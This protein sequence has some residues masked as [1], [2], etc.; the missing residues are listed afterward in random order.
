[1]K[2]YSKQKGFSTI[3][4]SVALLIITVGLTAAT[5]VIFG[6]RSFSSDSGLDNEALYKAQRQIEDAR[7]SARASFGSVIS[8]SSND[9]IYFKEVVVS[10]GSQPYSKNVISRISWTAPGPRSEKIELSTTL[11]DWKNALVKNQPCLTPLSGDWQHPQMA[12]Y[13]FGKDLLGDSS[14]GYPL[15]G[16]TVLNSKLYVTVN[17]TNGNNFPSLFI[18]DVSKPGVKPALLTSADNDPG[19]KSGL[20]AITV[21]GNYAYV[22]NANNPN[23]STCATCGQLQIFDI[24]KTPPQVIDTFKVPGV[25][26]KNGQSIGTSIFYKGGIVYLG[27]AKTPD[28]ATGDTEFNLIDVG[29]G[30]HGGSP[31][32]PV[33]LGGYQVGNGVNAIYA[34]GKYAYIATPNS[35]NMTILDVSDPT[36]PTRAGGYSPG[37]GSNGESLFVT[38]STVYLGRTFGTNEFY[39][40]NVQNPASITVLGSKD[41]GSGSSTS[42]NGVVLRSNL[43]FLITNT[44]FQIWNVANPASIT[45]WATPL[46]LPAGSGTTI[47][48]STDNSIYVGSLPSNDKGF[49]SIITPGP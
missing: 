4:I 8:S 27:L 30:G 42:I 9:G 37:I 21:N 17:N 35:E 22:A 36:H 47:S 40:L 45:Q 46:S 7:A 14:S 38:G 10:S 19:V 48:C 28:G 24:S 49:I 41:I 20:N 3:E 31:T 15:T 25:T 39:I 11:S 43:A 33:F 23:F 16:I 2:K 12:F 44:Q 32:S 29:G 13:E 18:F 34:K 5:L 26:G 6:G 1:M